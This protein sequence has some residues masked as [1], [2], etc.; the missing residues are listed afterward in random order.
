MLE[1]LNEVEWLEE[2]DVGMVDLSRNMCA[3]DGKEVFGGND[4]EDGLIGRMG[5]G[6]GMICMRRQ[7]I[8]GG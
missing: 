1:R 8:E 7:V 2:E 6:E 3:G 5:K 4:E